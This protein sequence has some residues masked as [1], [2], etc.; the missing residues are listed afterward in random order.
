MG[1]HRCCFLYGLADLSTLIVYYF[2]DKWHY[3]E[4]EEWRLRMG[5]YVCLIFL[6]DLRSL[7]GTEMII[8]CHHFENYCEQRV[9]NGGGQGQWALCVWHLCPSPGPVPWA[10]VCLLPC[11]LLS[12]PVTSCLKSYLVWQYTFFLNWHVILYPGV[13]H[14]DSVFAYAAKWSP[15]HV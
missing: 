7:L 3:N 10:Q 15:Q 4:T 11:V 9:C 14:N 12:P 5:G 6:N 2:R 13:G 8:L 1:R